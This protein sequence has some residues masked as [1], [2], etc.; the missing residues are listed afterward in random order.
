MSGDD[1]CLTRQRRQLRN[2]LPARLAAD[3]NFAAGPRVADAGAD[4]PGPPAFVGRQIRKVGPVAFPG[5]DIY[6][7]EQWQATFDPAGAIVWEGGPEI[8]PTAGRASVRDYRPGH[9]V[10]DA[11]AQ[12]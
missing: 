2:N 5:V 8:A 7:T 6:A 10:I 12:R 11:E 4:L 9:I 3:Q 1:H